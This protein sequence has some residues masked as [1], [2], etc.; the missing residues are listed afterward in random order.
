MN[1]ALAL[2]LL[3]LTGVLLPLPNRAAGDTAS[4][5]AGQDGPVWDLPNCSMN[6]FF[7]R[8]LVSHL[9]Q[10]SIPRFA[11]FKRVTDAD[12]VKYFVGYGPGR[13]R[14]W[15]KFMFGTMVGGAPL[16]QLAGKSV[17]GS[18][19]TWRCRRTGTGG[20]DWRGTGADGRRRRSINIP[21]G[22]F[23]SYSGVPPKAAEYFD[24]I[25]NTMCC[26]KCSWCQGA[27]G[28]YGPHANCRSNHAKASSC[29][30][31]ENMCG[32]S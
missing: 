6:V 9:V 21:I 18:V 12:Y 10:F 11:T 26:G 5:T 31:R 29:I 17:R 13:Q 27:Q 22:G 14:S 16:E 25:L 32:A 8:R 15:L 1:G 3:A 19:R 20:T 23:A 7:K 4:L 2:I 28:R 30:L 24:R